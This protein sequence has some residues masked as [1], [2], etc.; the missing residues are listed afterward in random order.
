MRAIGY[1]VKCREVCAPPVTQQTSELQSK[2]VLFR[3]SPITQQPA[4]DQPSSSAQFKEHTGAN[5]SLYDFLRYVPEGHQTLSPYVCETPTLCCAALA[6]ACHKWA[7]CLVKCCGHPDWG[8]MCRDGRGCHRTLLS[9]SILPSYERWSINRNTG[10][11]HK[12]GVT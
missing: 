5:P 9:V 1:R 2:G 4:Q 12:A 11:C 6:L 10:R 3:E 8:F 7:A